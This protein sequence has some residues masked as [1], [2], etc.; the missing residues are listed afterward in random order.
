MQPVLEELINDV[1]VLITWC[2]FTVQSI[3]IQ[4]SSNS[5]FLYVFQGAG[6]AGLLHFTAAALQG[7]VPLSPHFPWEK[8][9]G[10]L[11]ECLHCRCKAEY[12]K[13]H[14]AQGQIRQLQQGELW[15]DVSTSFT[16]GTEWFWEGCKEVLGESPSLSESRQQWTR[17]WATCHSWPCSVWVWSCICAGQGIVLCPSTPLHLLQSWW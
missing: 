5:Q 4:V 15:V 8:R 9:W 7:P 13:Q 2:I 6:R 1:I 10:F 3:A 11:P 14:S 17:L 12:I 16:L